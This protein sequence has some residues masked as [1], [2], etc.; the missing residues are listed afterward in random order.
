MIVVVTFD[1]LNV[2]ATSIESDTRS[3]P[4]SVLYRRPRTQTKLFRVRQS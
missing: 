1:P 4:L 2:I 3:L